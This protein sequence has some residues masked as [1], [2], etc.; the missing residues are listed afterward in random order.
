MWPANYTSRVG[1]PA[2]RAVR[3]EEPSKD[4]V[5]AAEVRPPA[6]L[7]CRAPLGGP[8]CAACGQRNIPPYP[9]LREL[10]VDAFSELS[11]WDGRFAV[12]VRA[13]VWRPGMLTRE[14]LWGRRARYISPLRLYIVASL[15]YFVL[16]A[17]A[18]DLERQSRSKGVSIGAGVNVDV[19]PSRTGPGSRPEQVADAATRAREDEDTLSAAEKAEVLKEISR[20]PAVMQPLLR[21]VVEDPTGLKRGILET[22]PRTFFV[23]LPVFAAIVALFYRGRRYPEHLYFA[24]HL[25]A[26]VFLVLA[27]PE[28]LSFTRS[29]VVAD[30]AGLGATIWILVYATRALRYVY[31]GTLTRTLAKELGIAAIYG[32]T[33]LVAFMVTI[34]WVSIAA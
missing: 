16:A 21:R 22:L 5:Q 33:T 11:G 27:V 32:L 9:T 23:L 4:A 20:T 24:L 17:A 3:A 14:F 2:G 13:L 19:T 15:A 30:I 26:F 6:C 25:H 28:L 29:A 18:P 34:Y 8:F 10:V 7:N 31:G 1:D 12:T